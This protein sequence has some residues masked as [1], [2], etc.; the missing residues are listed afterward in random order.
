MFAPLPERRGPEEYN[1]L[2]DFSIR[3]DTIY[4]LVYSDKSFIYSYLSNGDFIKK[5]E[6]PQRSAN[7]ISLFQVIFEKAAHRKML[8]LHS[9]QS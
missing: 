5:T 7:L 1:A 4:L 8:F 3:N 6:I 9:A 2:F